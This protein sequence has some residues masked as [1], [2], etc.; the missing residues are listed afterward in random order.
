MQQHLQPQSPLHQQPALQA[1]SWSL[2][3]R[4]LVCVPS[5]PRPVPASAPPT[6]GPGVGRLKDPL[7]TQTKAAPI[8]HRR[9]AGASGARWRYRDSW[10]GLGNLGAFPGV[11][12][13]LV[14]E[15][16]SLAVLWEG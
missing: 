3:S 16:Q 9:L 5:S 13:A 12:G 11:A 6:S 8:A 15:G 1:S 14:A 2:V 7:W 10:G 4:E